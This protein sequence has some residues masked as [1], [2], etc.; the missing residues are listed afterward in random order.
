MDPL[1]MIL[2]LKSGIFHCYVSLPEGTQKDS[3]M[4]SHAHGIHVFRYVGKMVVPLG[5]S[6]AV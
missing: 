6:L 4:N 3:F 5:G 1:K 2:L